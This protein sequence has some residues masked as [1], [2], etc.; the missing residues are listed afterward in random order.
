MGTDGRV[1]SEKAGITHSKPMS[2]S[3]TEYSAKNSKS[4]LN[5]SQIL[6]IIKSTWLAPLLLVLYALGK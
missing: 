3:I 5:F 4:I 6:G 1:K 2:G